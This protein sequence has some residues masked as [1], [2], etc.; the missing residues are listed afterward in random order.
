MAIH[1]LGQM[2]L[3]AG[4][5]VHG[6]A[7]PDVHKHLGAHSRAKP[8]PGSASSIAHPSFHFHDD[9]FRLSTCDM[10]SS[11][12][13]G[14]NRSPYA[15]GLLLMGVAEQ[16]HTRHG[17]QLRRLATDSGTHGVIPGR[18]SLATSRTPPDGQSGTR[19]SEGI[20][21]A[22]ESVLLV[23]GWICFA[24]CS[25]DVCLHWRQTPYQFTRLPE[26]KG[27][28]SLRIRW[29]P[30]ASAGLLLPAMSPTAKTPLFLPRL[31][32]RPQAASVQLAHLLAASVKGLLRSHDC[33]GT[34]QGSGCSRASRGPHGQAQRTTMEEIK[35]GFQVVKG[36]HKTVIPAF[37]I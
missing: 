35:N 9:I 16:V 29:T 28:P 21:E 22:R 7:Y 37:K 11:R 12:K 27:R 30:R 6:D 25:A 31:S 32:L 18:S 13:S 34:T 3:E 17:R 5:I 36:A 2:P 23:V 15:P 14:A 33:D 4:E 20:A 10:L 26:E 1:L 24:L 19:H 8:R